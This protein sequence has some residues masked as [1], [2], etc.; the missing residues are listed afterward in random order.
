MAFPLGRGLK[1]CSSAE[2]PDQMFPH[3]T[4]DE[5]HE[6]ALMACGLCDVRDECLEWAL[7]FPA[8]QDFGVW[9][10]TTERERA[11]IRRQRSRAARKN[12]P[13][14]RPRPRRTRRPWWAGPALLPSPLAA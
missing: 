3:P 7:T 1:P 11:K 13:K 5:G 14:A 4:D 9:G 2:R 8:S 12:E 6:V 10:G